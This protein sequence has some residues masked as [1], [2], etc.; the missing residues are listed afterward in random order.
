MGL[1]WRLGDACIALMAATG[2]ALAGPLH[3]AARAGDEIAIQKLL[4][5]GADINERDESGATPLIAAAL[6]SGEDEEALETI[7]YLL[8]RR[9]DHT[10]RDNRGMTV[11]HAA[12][13]AGDAESVAYFVGSDGPGYWPIDIDDHDN[14]QG[15]TPLMVAA[16]QN[17]GNVVAYLVLGGADKEITD[18][19][20]RTA[21][22]RAA[23]SG[24]DGIVR[25]LLR[26]GAKCQPA[27]PDW[28]AA[29]TALR[30]ELR[31]K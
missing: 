5:A 2:A 28:L 31:L 3:D 26:S 20:G 17:R 19:E 8:Q 30:T 13:F 4:D 23:Q 29:C 11:L 6:A 16:E 7:D 21:L 27:D 25:I 15:A 12:A 22:T 10:L 14:E 9:A 24:H 1:G 18:K